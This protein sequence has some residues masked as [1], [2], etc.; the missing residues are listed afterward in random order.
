MLHLKYSKTILEHDHHHLEGRSQWTQ[1]R[2][3]GIGLEDLSGLFQLQW[4]HGSMIL[5][6]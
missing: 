5:W 4:F 6:F 1:W 2:W 3:V